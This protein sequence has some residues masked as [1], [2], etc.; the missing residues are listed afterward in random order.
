MK[1]PATF[2]YFVA[3]VLGGPIKIGCSEAPLNR[4]ATL[5][6]WAPYQLQILARAPGRREDEQAIHHV[7]AEHWSHSEWFRPHPDI[8]ALINEIRAAG[9]IPE[10][11]RWVEG[12]AKG[13]PNPKRKRTP[14]QRAQQS[15]A[16]KKRWT[17]ERA[18]KAANA[19]ALP[20]I[21]AFL[22]ATPESHADFDKKFRSIGFAKS[23]L[24]GN[25]RGYARR[26]VLEFIRAHDAS[27]ASAA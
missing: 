9:V 16:Q 19:A 20:K 1:R 4:L 27:K 15:I 5:M 6:S 23:L 25:W 12:M 7:F 17:E 18:D 21:Q 13:V 10:K 22:M 2:V 14:E 3:P 11:F 24:A 8:Y 26:E